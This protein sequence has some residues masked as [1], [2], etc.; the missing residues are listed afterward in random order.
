MD[1]QEE[2]FDNNE[3]IT[4]SARYVETNER[5]NT[6]TRPGTERAVSL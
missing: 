3:T 1:D 2:P 6:S 5:N 4:V